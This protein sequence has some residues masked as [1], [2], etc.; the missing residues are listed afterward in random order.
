MNSILHK[1][2]LS[3]LNRDGH[4]LW[5]RAEPLRGAGAAGGPRPALARGLCGAVPN[6]GAGD[7]DVPLVVILLLRSGRPAIIRVVAGVELVIP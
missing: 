6:G 7:S 3:S 5:R 4:S 1:G 2:E